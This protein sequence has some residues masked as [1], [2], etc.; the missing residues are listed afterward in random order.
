MF[1]GVFVILL[2][3]Q[4]RNLLL[5]QFTKIAKI[6]T[7]SIG[8]WSFTN[9]HPFDNFTTRDTQTKCTYS[10]NVSIFMDDFKTVSKYF[11]FDYPQYAQRSHQCGPLPG[12]GH[13]LFNTN[14]PLSDAVLYCGA[15][16][17]L[18]FERMFDD[19]IVVVV[20]RESE[21][22]KFCHFPPPDKYDIKV[23]YRRNSTIPV[24][25]F[26]EGNLILKLVEMGQPD[27]PVGRENLVAGVISNCKFQWRTKYIT[28]LMDHVHIDQWG[29]CFKNT[30][31]DFWKNRRAKSFEELK[32]DLLTENPYKFLMSFENTVDPDYIT[33]K[34]FDSFLTRTIPIFYG[35]K[36]VFD[37]SPANHSLIYAN[38]YT[39]K[40]LAEVIKRIGNNDTLYSEFFKNWDLV[41]LHK[42]HK[43]YCSEDYVCTICR[44]VWEKLYNRKCGA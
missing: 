3:L 40:E 20:T 25:F 35:D 33:E 18:K 8:S 36:A 44:K 38:N 6:E 16:T 2:L 42:L 17:N 22:G 23:S 14:K 13:C 5:T 31:G 9:V 24:P 7:V 1:F 32:L 28:E 30:V 15:H 29:K 11:I 12:G 26:C 27:V 4:L 43:R 10:S 39:P 41:K 19:Q 37:F 34:I 21:M